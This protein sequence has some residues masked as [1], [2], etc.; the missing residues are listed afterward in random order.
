MG[1]TV[2]PD[3]KIVVKNKEKKKHSFMTELKFEK[4]IIIMNI[5]KI[6]FHPPAG[7]SPKVS[8]SNSPGWTNGGGGGYR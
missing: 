8:T 2:V 7:K 4:K 5:I 6:L 3:E 1:A